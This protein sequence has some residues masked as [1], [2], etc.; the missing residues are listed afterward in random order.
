MT[1]PL[2]FGEVTTLKPNTIFNLLWSLFFRP[3]KPF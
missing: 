1:E 3:C 2:A